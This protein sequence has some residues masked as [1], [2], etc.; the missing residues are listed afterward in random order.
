MPAAASAWLASKRRRG[1][2]VADCHV[3]VGG[4]P[5]PEAD[6]EPEGRGR[7]L[8]AGCCKSVLLCAGEAGTGCKPEGGTCK[9]VGLGTGVVGVAGINMVAGGTGDVFSI[10]VGRMFTEEN[11]KE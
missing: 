3:K 2:V 9:G 1:M 11:K 4:V 7:W 8:P 10:N 5:N 6:C